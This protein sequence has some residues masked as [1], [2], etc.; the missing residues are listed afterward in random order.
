MATVT[1]AEPAPRREP[2][3]VIPARVT[4]K[5]LMHLSRQLAAFL[6]AGIP[7]LDGLTLLG[8]EASNTTLR[9]TLDDVAD[10]LRQGEPLVL[11]KVAC[12]HSSRDR[13]IS[14]TGVAARKGIERAGSFAELLRAHE[15]A[16][17]HLWRRFDIHV[18]P[19]APT[20]LTLHQAIDLNVPIGCG[21]VAVFPDDWVVVDDDGHQVAPVQSNRLSE[22]VPWSGRTSD[23][24]LR[25]PR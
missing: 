14:E 23:A 18:R 9:R 21:G 8:R 13:A 1:A 25:R 6:R 15:L 7:I 19:A 4:G 2:R 17:K 16:W 12:I 11:E 22:L 20:N 10:G 3:E 5:D 24:S